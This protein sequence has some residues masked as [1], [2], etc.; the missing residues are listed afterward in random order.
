MVNCPVVL[1]RLIYNGQRNEIH[2]I[3]LFIML[4]LS[5]V[6]MPMVRFLR[7]DKK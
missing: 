2:L 7:I 5:L 1:F 4:A 6:I 3:K